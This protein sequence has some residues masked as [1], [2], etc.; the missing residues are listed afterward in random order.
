MLR[1][2]KKAEL[3]KEKNAEKHEIKQRIRKNKYS[4]PNK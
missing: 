4:L 1:E 3:S 2:Q